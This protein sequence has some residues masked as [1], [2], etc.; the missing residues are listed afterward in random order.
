MDD[1]R[2]KQ[3]IFKLQHEFPLIPEPYKKIADDIGIP[4]NELLDYM[5]ELKNNKTL[6]RIGAVLNHR[7]V[8]FLANAMVVWAVP[9]ERIKEVSDIMISFPQVSHCYEREILKNWNYN[10]YTMIHSVSYEL[11][12]DIIK[13]ISQMTN[14]SNYE[15][16]YS[17]KELK[18]S[19][20][21]YSGIK[22]DK[23]NY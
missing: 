4:E 17:T 3:I 2:E 6:R 15:V 11:C 14:I 5:I 1:S 18:K 10:I 20:M 7:T 21:L 23:N 12:D 8:G 22:S 9:A 19:S 13:Q 16:L